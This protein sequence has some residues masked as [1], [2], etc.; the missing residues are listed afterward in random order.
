MEQL[1]D[2]FRSP[3][4]R[5]ERTIMFI[6]MVD[7]TSMKEKEAEATWLT[8]F[9]FF[10]DLITGVI[11][12]NARGSIVKYLG[13]GIM[14]VYGE[15]HG[16]DAIND[17]VSIQ[18]GIKDSVEARKVRVHCSIG[19]STGEVV[20]FKTPRDEPDY[21]GSVVDRAARLC[22]VASAQAIFVDTATATST[23]MSKVKSPVGKV[24]RRTI[25][26]YQGAMGKTNLKGF[27]APVE[28]QEILWDQQLFGLKPIVVTADIDSART[29]ERQ[30][31]Q[32][33]GQPSARSARS[34]DSATA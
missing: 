14:A 5:V 19:I 26:E 3:A 9:G 27:T 25:N 23:Q 15:D 2:T 24:L 12:G 34:R 17:A 30:S 28:Y 32:S 13:D 33:E 31:S 29:R 11:E 20:E 6:D 7:S 18:K 8:T 22:A 10:F 4:S 21:L 16:S 1:S